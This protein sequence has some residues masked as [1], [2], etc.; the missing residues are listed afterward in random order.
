MPASSYSAFSRG[1]VLNRLIRVLVRLQ[2]P[3]VVAELALAAAY[4]LVDVPRGGEV[5]KAL[6]PWTLGISVVA[7]LATWGAAVRCRPA[8]LVRRVKPQVF[9]APASPLPVLAFTTLLPF[10]TENVSTT[11]GRVAKR[12]D[13]W[14]LWLD[15]L[16]SVIW[17]LVLAAVMRAVWSGFGVRLR[18]DGV[19]DR[20]LVGMSFVSWEALTSPIPPA[21]P[22]AASLDVAYRS[23]EMARG[24]AKAEGREV[25][26]TVNIDNHFLA[27][28]LQEYIS[29]PEFR[30]AIGTEGE[31]RRLTAAA[32]GDTHDQ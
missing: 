31:L 18:P 29:H 28:V 24:L 17:V 27:R 26:T 14:W 32:A 3:V 20:R 6:A 9:E 23:P 19:V 11:V 1:A 13:P 15:F 30:P 12:V 16:T 8:V 4:I 25:L 22:R 21:S 5:G 7:A 2:R 10:A